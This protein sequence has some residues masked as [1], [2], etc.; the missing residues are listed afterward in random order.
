MK[1]RRE[2][3]LVDR[4]VQVAIALRVL[5]H[6]VLF[7]VTSAAFLFFV[8][9]LSGEPQNAVSGLISRHAPTVIVALVLTPI[10]LVDL[11]KMTNRFAGPMVRLRRV[12][13]ELAAGNDVE[14]I[15]FRDGDFWQDLAV[16]FNRVAER[17]KDL[18]ATVAK[19][20]AAAADASP[21]GSCDPQLEDA[22][23]LN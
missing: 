5:M 3:N 10:F 2:R 18:E 8:E 1:N 16:E 11:F 17:V 12:M 22:P 23:V 21:E 6:A 14:S 13:G 7:V 20:E 19:L 15:K 9:L 4:S